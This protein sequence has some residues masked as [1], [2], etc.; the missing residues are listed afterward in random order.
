MNYLY[1]ISKLCKEYNIS[2][3]TL[4]Y[5]DSIGLLK[6]S[7]RTKANYRMYTEEDKARLEQI[8]LY[9]EAGIALEQIKKLLDS[10]EKSEENVL[11]KRLKEL[12]NELYLLR[13]QQKI[14]VEMLKG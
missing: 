14:I 6:A 8:C 12:N 13:L 1:S 4:L 11:K 10:N 9:R 2:R 7:E 5:Y 3:S